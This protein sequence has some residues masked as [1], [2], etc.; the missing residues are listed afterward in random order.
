MYT[1]FEPLCVYTVAAAIRTTRTGH[2][3]AGFDGVSGNPLD[4]I[5]AQAQC[6]LRTTPNVCVSNP[7]VW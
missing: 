5:Q 6:D 3:W 4:I 1:L 2:E 7:C